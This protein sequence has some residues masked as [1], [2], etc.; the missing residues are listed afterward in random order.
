MSADSTPRALHDAAVTRTAARMVTKSPGNGGNTYSIAAA[1]ASANQPPR[2]S[3]LPTQMVNVSEIDIVVPPALR[4]GDTIGVVAPSGPVN[5][6]RLARGLDALAPHFRIRT[7]PGVL[8]R[9]GYLAGDDRARAAELSAMLADPD[10]RAVIMARGGYGV[11]RMLA[12]VDPALVRRD[13]KPVIGFSD[14]TP[15]L[16]FVAAAGV[17]PI[18]GP[19]VAQLGELPPEDVAGLVRLLT[20]RA[21]LGR[22]P[23]TLTAIGAPPA[24]REPVIA[25]LVP[26]NLKML[27]H[28]VGT[29]WALDA[30]GCALLIEEIGEKPYALDRDLTQLAL[31]GLLR[32]AR[33]VVVGG[34]TRCTDPPHVPGAID[35][36][37]PARAAIDERLRAFALAG[38]DGAPVGHGAR[39][40]SLP[41]GGRARI[42]LHARTIDLLDAAVS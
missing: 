32:G 41:F 33:A 25:P 36:P 15:L 20:D 17:R 2:L 29:P 9:T 26:A 11:T 30:R 31:A 39:N 24:D 14:G 10:V 1:P 5:P 35:D 18:H 16:A 3:W 6:D 19:V 12:D 40:A 23:W 8:A 22:L 13:P 34:I 38:L 27:A 42:D 7:G 21:P 37:G 4:P 28:A